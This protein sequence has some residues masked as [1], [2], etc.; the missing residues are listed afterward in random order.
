M[1]YLGQLMSQKRNLFSS[2]YWQY[3]AVF[4]RT[5]LGRIAS[6]CNYHWWVGTNTLLHLEPWPER[7]GIPEPFLSACP[8]DP[9]T[10]QGAHFLLWPLPGETP[11]WLSFQSQWALGG[12]STHILAR[13]LVYTSNVPIEH[14]S[15]LNYIPFN[16]HHKS[17]M[18]KWNSL[19][20]LKKNSW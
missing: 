6:C 19:K 17:E 12:P 3:R 8:K 16:F 9:R 13:V 5:I 7:A 15:N 10:E 1:K 2:L 4:V 20:Y 14:S 11:S 18:D